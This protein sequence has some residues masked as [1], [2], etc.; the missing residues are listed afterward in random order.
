[1]VLIAIAVCDAVSEQG[2]DIIHLVGC[3]TRL[4]PVFMV[5]SPAAVEFAVYTQHQR[6]HIARA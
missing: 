2:R 4:H 3:F 6:D 1:L 5:W